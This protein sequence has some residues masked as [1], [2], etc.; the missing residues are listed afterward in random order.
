MADEPRNIVVCCD[1]T[2]NEVTG[3]LSNVL[4]LFRIA[5]KSDRQ[6]VYYDPGVGTIGTESAWQRR[7]AKLMAVWGLATGAGLDDNILDAYRFLV[8]TYRDGDRVF[9]FG[10][11]RGAYTVRA[12]AAFVDMVGLLWPD[13]INL[14]D[15]ALTT[16]KRAGW[17]REKEAER[18]G[19][20][21]PAAEDDG[22][23]SG[24]EAAWDF[25]KI[26]G[27]RRVPI[28]FMGCW[29]TVAS[30]IV[31]GRGPLSLP[32]LRTLP[33]TRSNPGVRAFRHAMAIDERR[34]MFRLNRWAPKRHV[35]TLKPMT[36]EEQDCEQVWFAGVH[37]DIGGGYPEKESGLSKY[38]LI[39][40]IDEATKEKHGLRI[41]Q[42]RFDR[43][44]KG[45]K[46]PG[47]DHHYVA[48]NACAEQHRSLKGVWWALETL[49]PK[50]TLWR[51]WPRWGLFGWYLPLAEPRLIPTG[52]AI[53]V[54]VEERQRCPELRYAPP[55]LP[56]REPIAPEG[57]F[58]PILRAISG[59][60]VLGGIAYGGVRLAMCWW[61]GAGTL[62]SAG[63][64]GLLLVGIALAA[65][66]IL[67]A[68][69]TLW[70][71]RSAG[72]K[73]SSGH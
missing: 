67:G 17:R 9:L 30:M 72:T 23:Q 37:S 38:P 70:G 54:S 1:G 71:L 47:E 52:A 7:K 45:I 65:L 15:Y 40:M 14:A 69:A 8:R 44:A 18:S 62:L 36:T 63:R 66:G 4:K 73:A 55:N 39:W 42:E 49:I 53:H 12:L 58:A 10:F 51:R 60:A 35:V 26:L 25:G 33:Y 43:L 28:H 21:A 11:S 6:I 57:L 5:E 31:P 29:D 24:F 20:S 50:S 13:Q 46:Q 59:A 22:K 3:D 68:V 19:G 2:G 61:H 41:S 56:R 48:P 16:Y 34:R 32:T 27:K 64:A